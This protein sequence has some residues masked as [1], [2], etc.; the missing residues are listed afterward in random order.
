MIRSRMYV[1]MVARV[2]RFCTSIVSQ[3]SAGMIWHSR[4]LDYSYTDMLKNITIAV[5]YQ[6][7]GQVGS[8]S[9]S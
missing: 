9:V 1:T 3:D 8:Y 6:R 2:A 7:G 4:N 5:D